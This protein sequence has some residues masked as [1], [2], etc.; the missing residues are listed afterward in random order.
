LV[1]ADVLDSRGAHL[2]AICPSIRT[3]PMTSI[4]REVKIMTRRIRRCLLAAITTITTGILVC[5]P[6]IAQ[7]G[8]S[9]NGID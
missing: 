1:S 4:V 3:E 6:T 2:L 8:L 9:F 7:A 5:L